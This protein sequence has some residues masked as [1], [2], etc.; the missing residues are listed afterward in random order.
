MAAYIVRRIGAMLLVLLALTAVIFILQQI[1]PF[2]PVR[3]AVGPEASNAVV[4]AARKRLGYDDPIFVQYLHYVEHAAVGN[5]GTSLRTGD[6]VIS[7]IGTFLPASLE[8]MLAALVIAAPLALLIGVASAAHWRG[9]SV[10]RVG[11]IVFAS[12]PSF[13]LSVLFVL[14]FY[15]RLHWLPAGGRT[16]YLNAPSGP[17]GLLTVDGLLHGQPDVT[18]N[19]IEHLILPALALGL[20]PAVAVGRVLRGALL[21]VMRYDHVQAARARGLTETAIVL[22]HCLR[23]AAGPALA[24]SGLM[25]GAMFASLVVVETVFAWPGLG[26]YLAQ[27]IPRGD[28]PAITGVTLLLGALYVITNTIVD[29]LQAIADPRIRA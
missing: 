26:S 9:A 22:K 8:L 23:N 5:L 14:L 29:I 7:D 20:L 16:S 2:D 27:S 10:L 6:S 21:T 28:F 12:A 19:A 25:L 11:S 24:M 4:A 15:A 13:V 17:T 3:V 1:S 18:V